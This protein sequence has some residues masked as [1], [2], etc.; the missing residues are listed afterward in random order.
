MQEREDFIGFAQDVEALK[1]RD[2]AGWVLRGIDN[3]ESVADHSWG[4]GMFAMV[5]APKFRIPVGHAV[6]MSIVHDLGEYSAPDY[7]PYDN[8][9][10]EEKFRQEEEAMLKLCSKMQG[11]DEIMALWRE[12]KEGKTRT[13]KFIKL[14]EYIEMMSQ[15]RFYGEEQPEVNLDD[16]WSWA[17]NYNFKNLQPLYDELKN[18]RFESAK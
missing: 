7:T 16:F 11:T 17:D 15:A 10:K 1:R 5:L 14:V 3:P 4:T 8:V 2:R 12:M 9:T 18:S 13:A 6:K